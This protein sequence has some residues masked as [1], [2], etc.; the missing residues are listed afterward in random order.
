MKAVVPDP[1]ATAA[2]IPSNVRPAESKTSL[3]ASIGEGSAN[4]S[5]PVEL[6]DNKPSEKIDDV[7]PVRDDFALSLFST[8][9]DNA[10]KSVSLSLF[11][12]KNYQTANIDA[13]LDQTTEVP[14][15]L[16]KL[17][18]DQKQKLTVYIQCNGFDYSRGVLIV[19]LRT[20]LGGSFTK[21]KALL[22]DDVVNERLKPAI[23]VGL[24]NGR[25]RFA[26]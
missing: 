17:Q 15:Q 5:E 19:T 25:Y 18:N 8:L 10:E 24:V 6:S 11:S 2:A 26:A 13:N 1:M 7:E 16:Q 14:H 12:H 22:V 21:M 4:V 9:N 3:P 20:I 23:Q